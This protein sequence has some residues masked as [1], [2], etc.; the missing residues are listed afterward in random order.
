MSAAWSVLVAAAVWAAAPAPPED[1]QPPPPP[2]GYAVP[3]DS[4][5][6][7]GVN[8]RAGRPLIATTYFY[9]YDA[10]SKAHVIDPD[11]SDALTDHPPTLEGFSY[12]NLAWH[13]GELS[14]M[15][16]AGIDVALPVYWGRSRIRP[17]LE[18]RRAAPA[19]GGPRA[20]A[21]GRTKPARHRHVLRHQHAAT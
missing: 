11:G 16:A 17:A 12:R 1:F 8:F 3:V 14:D 13:A 20:V 2:G 4:A 15:I 21:G 6:A 18:R 7:P 5:G 9:W 19:G 10:D